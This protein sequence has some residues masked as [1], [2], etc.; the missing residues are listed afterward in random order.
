M[1]SE[2]K[3]IAPPLAEAVEALRQARMVRD[4]QGDVIRARKAALA[5][6]LADD[7]TTF[8]ALSHAADVAELTARNAAFLAYESNPAHPSTLQAGV[9]V[10]LF[11]VPS[12][13]ADEAFAWAQSKDMFIT[14]P[15]LM[16]KE[17][18]SF[19]LSPAANGSGVPVQVV[20]EA[21]VQ[22]AS[23]LPGPPRPVAAVDPDALPWDRPV[24]RPM[25]LTTREL[26]D[27][28]SAAALPSGMEDI[29]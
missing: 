3:P 29:I 24:S 2:P 19:A 6:A 27:I 8:K 10:K 14:R 25:A 16:R 7:E 26:M 11:K 20:E 13:D 9:T 12:Y 4:A 1:S 15:T 28:A 5:K 17:F 18:E 23:V 21:R 22:F